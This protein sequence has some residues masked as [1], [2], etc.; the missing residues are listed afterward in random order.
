MLAPQVW[1]MGFGPLSL[2]GTVGGGHDG[3]L[4]NMQL[5]PPVQ[6]AGENHSA[7]LP[8]GESRDKDPIVVRLA[9]SAQSSASHMECTAGTWMK[10][11]FPRGRWG[12][13][14]LRFCHADKVPGNML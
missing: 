12:R 4:V 5:E 7:G 3:P 11:R 10:G 2:W 8:G 14:V 6:A 9:G 1:Q 13:E